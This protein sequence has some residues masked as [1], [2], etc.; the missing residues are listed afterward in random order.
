MGAAQPV[1]RQKVTSKTAEGS[2]ARQKKAI[3]PTGPVGLDVGTSHIIAACKDRNHIDTYK[4]LNAFFT[5]PKSNFAR[6]ILS[7]NDILHFE[8]G[9]H[10][11]IYGYSA[12]EFALMFHVN[13][14]RSI[15]KGLLSAEEKDSIYVVQAAVNSLIQPPKQFGETLCFATPGEPLQGIGS[16][17]YHESILK[18]FLTGM[19]Y[20]PISINEG[21]AVVLAELSDYD[22][23]G[24]GISM[25]GGMC[26]VCVSYLSFPVITFSIQKAGDYIDSMVGLSVDEPATKI[27]SIKEKNFDMLKEPKDRISTALHIFYEDVIHSLLKSLQRI[28]SS[29]EHLPMISK[30]M[31]IVLSGGTAMPAGCEEKFQKILQSY[32][33]PIQIEGVHIAKDPLNAT[34]KGAL[35]MALTEVTE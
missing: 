35:I 14:R 24:I 30:P 27:Q 22:Y 34:A 23:T 17:V 20:T 26:N 28:L 5:L 8:M 11:Y 32:D 29:S 12:Q 19:G 33:M 9:N 4:Q 25:G 16:V 2:E 10:F 21:M 7:K 3:I 1:D 13:T 31:P 15:K 6:N 18:R